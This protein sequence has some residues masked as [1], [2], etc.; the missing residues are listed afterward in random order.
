MIFELII[1]QAIRWFLLFIPVITAAQTDN[2][3]S[4]RALQLDGIDDY[5]IVNGNYS[6]LNLPFSVSAWVRLDPSA[7]F[8]T[9][10]FVTN[11]N[12]PVYR[13]FWFVVTPSAILCEFGDGEGGSNPAFRRGKLANVSD[14]AGRWVNVSAVMRAPF[15]I[16]VYLN[17]VEL[18]GSSWGGSF[19]PMRSAYSTDVPKIGYFLSNSVIYRDKSI[20][21]EVRLWSRALTEE[22]IRRDMCVRLVGNEPGLIG[23]WDFNETSGNTVFDKS[24]N[25]FHGQ[26][27]GNPTRVFS[28]APIGNSSAYLYT[29]NWSGKVVSMQTG[30]NK[31]TVKDLLGPNDGV[32]LYQVNVSPSQMDG[33]DLTYPTQPYFGAFLASQQ[34]PGSFQAEYAFQNQ[35]TCEVQ[36]R[37]DNSI[38]RWEKA[39]NPVIQVRQRGEFLRGKIGDR[40]MLNLGEDMVLCDRS[41]YEISTGLNGPGLAFKWNT[42]QVTPSIT[43][44]NNGRYIVEVSNDCSVA[45]DTIDIAF[46]STPKPF[47]FGEDRFLCEPMGVQLTVTPSASTKIKWQDGSSEPTFLVTRHGTYSAELSNSCGRAYDEI[48]FY[49][50]PEHDKFFPNVLT[51]NN[52]GKNDRFVIDERFVGLLSLRVFNRWGKEVYRSAAYDNSWTP[53]GLSS[54]TYYL[55]FEGACLPTTKGIL[56]IVTD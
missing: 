24:P 10:V 35:T 38:N 8:V 51:P 23:Y 6:S 47:S 4:G 22:E 29:T 13:G 43:V 3:G 12:D 19:L 7:N 1:K 53:T 49:P 2:V 55:I 16:S 20:I 39:S 15:D 21:D 48:T 25:G 42:G 28:G 45:K 26:L 34:I 44:T 37:L 56:T 14:I 33:L 52:D 32:H 50:F 31:F 9:P 27:V 40:L 36:T 30:E 46:L 41:S 54:G 5:V 17:G 11:D 18:G